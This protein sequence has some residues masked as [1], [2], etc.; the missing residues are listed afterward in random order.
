MKNRNQPVP[1]DLAATIA[2]ARRKRARY[3]KVLFRLAVRA[4]KSRIAHPV[5]P[6]D[7]RVS[8]A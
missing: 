7:H 3:I 4:V 1:G 2:A 8:H 6:T 5:L